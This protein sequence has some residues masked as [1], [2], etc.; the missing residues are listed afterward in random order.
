ML[1][2]GSS[3]YKL[4][5]FSLFF[6]FF[7]FFFFQKYDGIS[8]G[9]N[10]HEMSNTFFLRKMRKYFKMSSAQIFTQLVKF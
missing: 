4:I 2:A 7:F 1:R 9:G 10:L 8:Y 3:N 5:F 6:F